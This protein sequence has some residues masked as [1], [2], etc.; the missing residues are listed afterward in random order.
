[1]PKKQNGFGN[2]K[3]LS[4][5]GGGRVDKGKAKGAA[6]TYPSNRRYGS[7][8]HRSVIEQ[9]DLDSDWV[10]WRKGYEY[11][12]QA[13]WYRLED[14][15]PKKQTYSDAQIQS[16]LYQGTDYEV[17]VV[18]DGYK[19]A[20]K[21]A[22]SNNHYV[23]KR[24]CVSTPDLGTITGVLNDPIKYPDNKARREI[25]V[26][27]VPGADATLLLFM[28]GERLTDGE[29]TATLDFILNSDQL[30]ALYIGKSFEE[31][32]TVT[33]TA[34][35]PDLQYEE[36]VE[37]IQDFN[38]LVGKIVYIPNFFVEK[39]I[40]LVDTIEVTDDRDYF[41]LDV[42]DYVPQMDIE[43][44]DPGAEL[45]PPSLYDISQLPKVLTTTGTYEVRGKYIYNKSIY[46]RFFGKQYL[47]GE[48]A[49]STIG[50]CAYSVMPFKILGVRVENGLLQIDSVPFTAEFK[51]MAP[52]QPEGRAT[53]IF[54]D[55]SFTKES[56]DEYGPNNEY[57]HNPGKPGS[58]PWMRIDTDV[59]PWMDE[60]FTSGNP[61]APA[62]VYTCSCPSYSHAMLSAPQQT[63][64]NDTRKINRQRR[65]PL[66]TVLGQTDF[67]ALGKNQAAGKI[68]SWESREQRMG[69]KMCKHSI[70][71]MFIEKLKVKEPNAYP[72]FE[73]REKFED[74]LKTE[75]A[76][77]AEE[78]NQSYKRGGITTLEVVF[79]L[80]QGLNLDDIELAYVILNSNF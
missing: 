43:I 2:S 11:Y 70:A 42:F 38:E 14:Y 53:L 74:K 7:S 71:A 36:D 77:V 25:W 72:S 6:G 18:F 56:I 57:Y 60:V 33:V 40:N 46:Q 79:A 32:T 5:K 59:D 69:V 75:I 8:V 27:G 68:E 17:D 13:A 37:P 3:S 61:I 23:M 80:A 48:L 16:K 30:P 19:F 41:T 47:T 73:S 20:T 1:M 49:L 34:N 45:L 62:T 58:E 44:L 31:M 22:D 67:D 52:L 76:E 15:D 50:R 24:T 55:Y 78:F 66:P 9:Y 21:N 28:I 63:D 51:L 10:K 54:P 26:D 64:D 29:T 4:F 39:D 65:Y 12:N 35:I